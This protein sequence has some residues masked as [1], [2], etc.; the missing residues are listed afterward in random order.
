M[1]EIFSYI[2]FFVLCTLWAI[3][4]LPFTVTLH[5]LWRVSK[6]N[7]SIQDLFGKI[8][9]GGLCWMGKLS[10]I[11]GTDIISS[12]EELRTMLYGLRRD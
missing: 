2:A 5:I 8:W 1:R 6:K 12:E 4:L 9:V 11:Y 3:I 7:K 10:G